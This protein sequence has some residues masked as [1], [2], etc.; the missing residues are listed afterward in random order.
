MPKNRAAL[1]AKEIASKE[2]ANFAAYTASMQNRAMQVLNVLHEADFRQ[3]QLH[4]Q[5]V[6][7]GAYFIRLVIDK[8]ELAPD[9]MDNLIAICDEYDCGLSL[10]SLFH[11]EGRVSRVALWVRGDEKPY[12]T[13]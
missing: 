12:L 1:S 9:R 3:V 10:V 5:S 2:E 13:K 7:T 8:D 4:S 11:N 6:G